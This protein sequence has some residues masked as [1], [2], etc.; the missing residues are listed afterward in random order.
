MPAA[1]KTGDAFFMKQAL[2]LARKGLGSTS[3]NPAVGAV[4]V[5][6]GKV[7]ARGFHKKAGAPHAEPEAFSGATG[8]VKGA[9][10]YVT[11]E[12]C[13]HTGK[14]TPPCTQGIIASGVKKVVIGALDPNPKV[15]G[16]GAKALR[17][18]GIE[19][20]TGVLE[21][22]CRAINGWYE[23]YIA[24]GL[25]FVTLKLASTLD[26][27]VATSTCESKWITC[28]ESRKAVHRLRALNDAI[29]V[30]SSTVIEDDPELTT[31]LVKGKSPK[32][33]I[34]D[35]RLSVP[36]S[37]KIFNTEGG[38]VIIFTSDNARPSRIKAFEKKGAV[39]KKAR[40][41]K[42][43]LLDLR[44]VIEELGKMEV[45]SVLCEGGPKVAASLIRLGL[46][47]RVSLFIA[48]KLIGG[49]GLAS[50]ASLGVK[51]L[52][53]APGIENLKVS[54]TGCDIL[55]EG[56]LKKEISG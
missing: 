27:K 44:A 51:R 56:T 47:D 14:K 5:K 50:I 43:G 19:V 21:Q 32:R 12:P 34:L 9:T 3:P 13:C 29:M 39:V 36:L 28:L 11:L 38:Q 18:A 54:S 25:P 31:R 35:S 40:T 52:N 48:P 37:S 55:I 15:S 6:K 45:A 1:V 17:A 8:S 7:I 53:S 22:E 24:T 30:G 2:L 23:K 26:G 46:A 20:I 33:V 16:R 42:K 10:L 4:I 41:D 49:D